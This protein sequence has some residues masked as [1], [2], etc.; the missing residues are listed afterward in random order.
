MCF[1]QRKDRKTTLK[2]EQAWKIL[3]CWWKWLCYL[4]TLKVAEVTTSMKDER[5]WSLGEMTLTGEK[6]KNFERH[7]SKC[8]MSTASP[9]MTG[10]RSKAGLHGKR[11]E[12]NLLRCGTTSSQSANDSYKEFGDILLKAIEKLMK[13]HVW[14]ICKDGR[15]CPRWILSNE[16]IITY[17]YFVQWEHNKVPIFC[18]MVT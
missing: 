6:M 18:P 13:I 2:T 15:M 5:L 7:L 11:L 14:N 3:H 17:L 12:T 4:T 1:N 16:N 10:L 9:T 8:C